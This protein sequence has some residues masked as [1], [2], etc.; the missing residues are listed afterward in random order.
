VVFLSMYGIFILIWC[1]Y[2]RG[3]CNE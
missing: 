3:R 1:T 2:L